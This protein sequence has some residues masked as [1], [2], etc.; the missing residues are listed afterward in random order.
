MINS[1]SAHELILAI[2]TA[3][4]G[5]FGLLFTGLQYFIAR[6]KRRDDLFSLRFQYYKKIERMWLATY[7]HN[8][9]PLSVEDLVEVVSEAKYLF[10]NEVADHLISFE[11]RRAENPITPDSDF[12]KPFEKYLRL[13]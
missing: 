7:N 2:T 6:Q 8:N 5:V 11:N 4:V 3:L 9:P 10:G 13:Q 12:S 1:M